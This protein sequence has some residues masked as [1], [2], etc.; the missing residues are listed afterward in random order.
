MSRLRV[1]HLIRVDSIG[2]A[3]RVVL[4]GIPALR[5]CGVEASLGVLDACEGTNPM[6][7]LL[8]EEATWGWHCFSDQGRPKPRLF[9]DLVRWVKVHRISLLHVHGYRAALVGW[10]VA[11]HVGIPIVLTRHGVLSRHLRERL[12]ERLEVEVAN[13]MDAVISVA[14]HLTEPIRTWSWVIPNGIPLPPRGARGPL[15][16][17]PRRL[18]F[19][20][21]L[22]QEKNPLF[23][24]ELMKALRESLM[25]REEGEWKEGEQEEGEQKEGERKGDEGWGSLRLDIVGEGGLERALQESIRREGMERQI[26]L[27]GFCDPH[28]FYRQADLLLMTSLREGLPLVALEALSYGVPVLATAVGGLPALLEPAPACGEVI[29]VPKHNGSP[30]SLAR[31]HDEGS[32]LSCYVERLQDWLT[33]PGKARAFG[34]N[35]RKRVAMRFGMEKWAQRHHRLYRAVCSRA[36]LQGLEF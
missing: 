3:E 24:V 19:V 35:G 10:L 14:P 17:R 11:R 1:L 5:V 8:E 29:R 23:L 20:G 2:G 34:E 21:R 26:H 4:N 12:V 31:N 36:P 13:R 16:M 25:D 30:R 32:L 7:T 15:A 9:R 33:T 27:H 6:E 22:S 28:P 18:L